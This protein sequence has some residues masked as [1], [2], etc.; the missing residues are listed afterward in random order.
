L[1]TSIP[2]YYQGNDLSPVYA[3]NLP[4]L[5]GRSRLWIHGHVHDSVDYQAGKTRVIS[6]PRGYPRRHGATQENNFF[7]P[8]FTVEI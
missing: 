1:G 2:S 3:S 6:N 7:D 5:L 8:F 4:H